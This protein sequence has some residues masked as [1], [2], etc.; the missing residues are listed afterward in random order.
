M[1]KETW[2]IA[3]N[4]IDKIK[5]I[6]GLEFKY[7]AYSILDWK[8][9]VCICTNKED[10]HVLDDGSIVDKFNLLRGEMKNEEL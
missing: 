5:S 10:I 8:N 4:I 2:F 6:D 3:Y 1:K 9:G 7:T